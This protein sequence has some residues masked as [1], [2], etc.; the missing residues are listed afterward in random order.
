MSEAPALAVR[1]MKDRA[2]CALVGELDLAGHRTAWET[3]APELAAGR[4]FTLD[5]RELRFMDSSGMHL[6]VHALAVLG[7][8]G[9]LV[10]LD[11]S[12]TVRRVLEISG[13]AGRPNLEVR[14]RDGEV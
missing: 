5:V 6:I 4:E 11:P 7:D 14:G 2:G 3:I 8:E 1:P 12:P 9:R 13:L 10:I